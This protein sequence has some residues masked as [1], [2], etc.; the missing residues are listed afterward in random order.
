M[1]NGL[2]TYNDILNL[3]LRPWK[4]NHSPQKYQQLLNALKKESYQFQPLYDVAFTKP[5]NDKRKFYHALITNEATKFL[6]EL[7]N[8]IETALISQEK[9]H[10]VTSTLDKKLKPKFGEIKNLIEKKNFQ[11]SS[12][13]ITNDDAYIIQ[14][15]KYQLIR[16]YLEIQDYYSDE[17]EDEPLT[18]EDILTNFFSDPPFD[19]AIIIHEE[20]KLAAERKVSTAPKEAPSKFVQHNHEIRDHKDGVL[21]YDEIVDKPEA[22]GRVEEIL[23][24]DEYIDK[25]LKFRKGKGK[26]L[27]IAAIAHVLKQ[28][29]FFKD[30]AF[31]D[32]KRITVAHLQI[33]RFISHRYKVNID[34]QYRRFK[35]EETLSTFLKSNLWIKNIASS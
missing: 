18:Q 15:L 31:H 13:S 9:T 1:S 6:N 29:K 22:L 24:L 34:Q 25:D 21:L 23:F 10:W 35:K 8:E 11:L 7:H 3:H 17:I 14:Y 16:L 30:K 4:V 26:Q 32:G 2:E 12:I 19:K 20:R 33:Q 27:V 5:V 28:K